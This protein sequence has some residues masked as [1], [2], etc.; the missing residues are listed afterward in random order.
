MRRSI[1]L[2]CGFGCARAVA[3]SAYTTSFG[4]VLGSGHGFVAETGFSLATNGIAALVACA[5]VLFAMRAGRAADGEQGSG[6]R[7]VLPLPVAGVACLLLALGYVA[8][9]AGWF[10]V[11][12]HAVGFGACALLYAAG[13]V[14]LTSSWFE[15]FVAERDVPGVVRALVGGYLVQAGAYAVLSVLT[16]WALCGVCIAVLAGTFALMTS[17]RAERPASAVCTCVAGASGA[18]SVPRHSLRELVGD[19]S[20]SFLC[21]F[22]LTA[23]V[24]F[25][26]TSVLG[27]SFEPVIAL[28]SMPIALLMATVLLA[29]VVFVSH[30]VPQASAVYRVLF[31]VMLTVLSALPFVSQALGHVAGTAMVVCYDLVGMAFVL[32][33]LEVAHGCAAPPVALMGV[34]QAGTHLSLVAGLALGLGLNAVHVGEDVSYA[35]VLIL[36]CIYLLS[37]VLTY[38]SRRRSRDAENELLEEVEG[39]AAGGVPTAV[40][41][42]PAAPTATQEHVAQQ[43][44]RERVGERVTAYALSKGLTPR[45]AQ[46]AVQLARGRTAGAIACDLGISENT[47]WAHIKHVYVKLGVHG[48][49]ELIEL[50]EREVIA[51]GD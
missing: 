49:Q 1:A 32:L 17:L 43:V 45:E 14:I 47:A 3:S 2:A 24:G 4:T 44:V 30:R 40:E 10:A 51:A 33:L 15:L 21:V 11:L 39:A 36:V 26:H 34:Y 18:L 50:I 13:T 8:G 5:V 28:V 9:T 16:G 31:P 29:G 35:T 27:N 25:L 20:G 37:M 23:V 6:R 46:V 42:A 12:P 7:P 19:L 48:K 41:P 22:V 38:L